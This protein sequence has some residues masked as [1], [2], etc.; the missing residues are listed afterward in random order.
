MN[1]PDFDAAATFI[2]ANARVIDRRRFERLFGD[3]A[4]QPVRDAVA[5]YRNDDGGFGHA[6]EPDCRA[7]G[8]QA[9]A[10]EMALRILDEAD[11]WD[12]PLV[13]G[14][15][16]WLAATAPDEGG[17]AGAEPSMASWPHA[18]WWVAEEGHPASIIVTGLIAG[19]LHARGVTHP[20][21]D[22]ATEV[23]WAGIA[24]L[25]PGAGG[26]LSDGPG[27]AYEMLGV[28]RFLQYVPDRD[29][30]WA[31]FG[32]VSPLII[33]RG[34][35]A[36]D[37]QESGEVHTPLDYAPEPTSMARE[38]FDKATIT[39]HLDQFARAQHAD[40]GWMFNWLAWSPAAEREWR[41]FLTVDALR[42]LRANGYLV[43]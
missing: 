5:A 41:G 19:T 7:P 14:A 22:R 34:L 28:L 20:W 23:M 36:L 29:R 18:P 27:G 4:A 1:A 9:L 11:G 24:G 39:A 30:A 3:G 32:Q 21:L 13:T 6:L 16:D 15:C 31:A 37:P 33:D 38:L 25:G 40:G 12:G 43:S 26:G 8:S 2:A 17:A 35:V 42:L 10:V